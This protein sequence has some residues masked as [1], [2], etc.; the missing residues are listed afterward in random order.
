MKNRRVIVFKLLTTSLVFGVATLL[1]FN[2]DSTIK[3][4]VV[5]EPSLFILGIIFRKVWDE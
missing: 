3:F 5:F 2:I 1:G 4:I